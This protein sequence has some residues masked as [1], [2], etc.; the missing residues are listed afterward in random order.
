MTSEELGGFKGY[1]KA[2]ELR[3]RLS[4]ELERLATQYGF[5]PGGTRCRFIRKRGH[6]SH[7]FR[8]SVCAKSNWHLVS[9]ELGA[10]W[11]PICDMYNKILLPRIP[12]RHSLC[13]LGISNEFP[14]RGEY[15][16]DDEASVLVACSRLENDF[17]E[18]AL[19]YFEHHRDLSSIEATLN[20]RSP[21][22]TYLPRSVPAACTG[23]IAAKLC[24]KRDVEEMARSYYEYFARVQSPALAKVILTV[25]EALL[26][27]TTS[28]G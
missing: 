18:I 12:L 7:E 2:K 5:A 16:V 15:C 24:G 1:V 13:G 23:L 28:P 17:K 19:P 21:D 3:S 26:N 25:R 27:D 9:P 20:R 11:R 14:N 8:I 10:A 22:G 4:A 6:L